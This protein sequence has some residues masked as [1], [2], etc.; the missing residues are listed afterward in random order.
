MAEIE[1]KAEAEHATISNAYEQELANLI[2]DWE[3]KA[4]SAQEAINQAKA[5]FTEHTPVKVDWSTIEPRAEQYEVKSSDEDNVIADIK[6]KLGE[7]NSH[8]MDN[9]RKRVEKPG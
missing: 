7:V 5:K 1:N 8:V 4:R 3:Q 2:E 6:K 9:I